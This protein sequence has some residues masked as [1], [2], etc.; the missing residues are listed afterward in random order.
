MAS[1]AVAREE[2][3]VVRACLHKQAHK[4]HLSSRHPHCPTVYTIACGGG[5]TP[6][7]RTRSGAGRGRWLCRKRPRAPAPEASAPPAAT[8][9]AIVHHHGHIPGQGHGHCHRDSSGCRNQRRAPSVEAAPA[10]PATLTASSPCRHQ[11]TH[12]DSPSSLLSGGGRADHVVRF[13]Q[14]SKTKKTTHHSP[15]CLPPLSESRGRAGVRPRCRATP[16]SSRL[17]SLLPASQTRGLWSRRGR[18]GLA[19]AGC[20]SPPN[21]GGLS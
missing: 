2:G 18:P 11:Q 9:M 6:A 20:P 19:G 17:A 8:A 16:P 13:D 10:A 12:P 4:A 1:S 14:K 7:S 21:P 5:E 3:R 15:R